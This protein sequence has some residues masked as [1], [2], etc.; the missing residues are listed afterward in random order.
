MMHLHQEGG[1]Q[2]PLSGES[3]SDTRNGMPFCS[4]MIILSY[5]V[6]LGFVI[7]SI[8]GVTR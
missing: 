7:D 6:T 4:V 5:L 1:Q 3:R 8:V 2:R